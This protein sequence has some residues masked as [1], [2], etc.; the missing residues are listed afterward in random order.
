MAAADALLT[1]LPVSTLRGATPLLFVLLGECLTQRAGRIN[2]GVEGQMLVGAA[3][4]Y[5]VTA[6]SGSPALGLAAGAAAGALLSTV[7]A[8]LTVAVDA[9]PF[10]SGLAVWMLG[11]GV[12]AFAG[13]ALVGLRIDGWMPWAGGITP[14]IA[15][16]LALVPVCGFGLLHTRTGLRWR[17]VGESPEHA[18]AAG[19][20]PWHYIVAGV[21]VGGVLSGLGGAALSVDYT[22]TWA[23]GMTAGRGLVAVGLVIVARW[24]PWLAL[25]AALLFGLAEALSLRLQAA[26][27]AVSAHL[28]H[29]LP[30]LASLGVFAIT[31]ARLRRRPGGGAPA[32]L[33]A[34][35]AR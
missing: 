4:G 30:Y 14:T 23:E 12:S 32:A 15:L 27:S 7:F 13:T 2:L 6:L 5:G 8:V 31:C 19:V 25:P 26:D 11:F 24:N 33:G 10:A 9:D 21:L 28:L 29:T 1:G 18:R 35:L 16:A 34:L 17:A 22:R 3:A 20:T